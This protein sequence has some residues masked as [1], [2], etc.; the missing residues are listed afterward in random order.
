MKNKKKD[1]ERKA[2]KRALESNEEKQKRL[3]L[4]ASRHKQARAQETTENYYHRLN[5]DLIR[6]KQAHQLKNLEDT[7]VRL[8]KQQIRTSN[9]R[10]KYSEERKLFEKEKNTISQRKFRGT[11]VIGRKITQLRLY[12]SEGRIETSKQ[13]AIRRHNT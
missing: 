5:S 13:R 4:D 8:A 12:R 2:N 6:H 9:L 11:R 10:S 7:E 1:R 3:K